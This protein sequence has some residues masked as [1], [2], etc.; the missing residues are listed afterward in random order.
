MNRSDPSV[1][2]VPERVGHRT[3][4]QSRRPVALT[5]ADAVIGALKDIGVRRLW[6]MP[7]GGSNADLIQATVRADLP[8]LWLTP[9]PH[10]RS[11]R[12]RKPS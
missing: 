8:S 3:D 2:A 9:S 7:G 4:P 1:V 12:R 6:G 11:W 5:Y 10:W